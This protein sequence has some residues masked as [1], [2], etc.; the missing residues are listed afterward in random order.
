[1]V[2]TVGDVIV[3]GG[4]RDASSG[5]GGLRGGSVLMLTVRLGIE[6]SPGVAER[7]RDAVLLAALL[8][9]RRKLASLIL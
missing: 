4:T 8:R 2:G 7:F 9:S 1:M 5:A 6:A 3:A